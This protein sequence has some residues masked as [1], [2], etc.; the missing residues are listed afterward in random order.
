MKKYMAVT[1]NI[2]TR[3]HPGMSVRRGQ[4]QCMVLGILIIIGYNTVNNAAALQLKL[5]MADF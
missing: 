5:K 3:G 4:A 1:I 2:F